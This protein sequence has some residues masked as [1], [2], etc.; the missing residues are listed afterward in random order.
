MKL[1]L[2]I[3]A[4]IATIILVSSSVHTVPSGSVGFVSTFDVINPETRG[5]GVTFTLPIVQEIKTINVQQVTVPEEFSVQTK[6]KQVIKVT[7]TAIYNINPDNA[8]TTAINIGTNADKIKA[9]A[10]QPQLL[11]TVKQAVA[12]YDMDAAIGE[13]EVI[14]ANIEA[15]L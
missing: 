5:P 6:D 3:A 2:L 8:A 15:T 12:K 10:F 7:G 11:A 13:Q 9:N 4:L 14:G 1:K